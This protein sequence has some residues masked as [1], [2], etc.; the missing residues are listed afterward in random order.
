MVTRYKRAP[1][2]LATSFGRVY[3][4]FVSTTKYTLSGASVTRS[5]TTIS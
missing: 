2:E 5:F 4:A 3:N 1:D